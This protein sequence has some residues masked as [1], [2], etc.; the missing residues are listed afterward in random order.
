MNRYYWTSSQGGT[1]SEEGTGSHVTELG[2]G[3]GLSREVEEI[4]GSGLFGEIG[5]SSVG[6]RVI[7]LELEEIEEGESL[8]GRT[9]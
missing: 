1:I 6:T 8:K 2:S 5:N 4:G 7:G 9:H 3:A